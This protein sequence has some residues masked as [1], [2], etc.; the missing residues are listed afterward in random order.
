M[1]YFKDDYTPVCEHGSTLRDSSSMPEPKGGQY[2]DIEPISKPAFDAY[3]E[4]EYEWV[5]ADEASSQ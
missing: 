5:D 1:G 2:V 4:S 3:K